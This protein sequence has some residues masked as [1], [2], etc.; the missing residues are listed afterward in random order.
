MFSLQ[1]SP[2]RRRAISCGSDHTVRLWDTETGL[3]V[4]TLCGHRGLV[5]QVELSRDGNVIYSA[6]MDCELR[7][8]R[9]PPLDRLE[10]PV[11]EKKVRL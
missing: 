11:K 6:G 9:A 2:D 5:S 3:E 8:R 10:A 1:F 4:G 7:I